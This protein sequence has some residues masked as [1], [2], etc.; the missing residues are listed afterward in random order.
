MFTLQD[1]ANDSVY[2]SLV[3]P[4]FNEEAR[5]AK[6][7]DRILNFL[8][9]QPYPA[10]VII[11]DDGSCDQ[12]VNVVRKIAL[13]T[14][15]LRILQSGANYGKGW[16][17][18]S[19][20]L[21]ARGSYLFF[22][23]ADLSVPIEVLPLF[24]AKLVDGFDVTIGTR[25][26]T[27]AFIEVHQPRYRELM[28][29]TYTRLSN[30]ILGLQVSDFTCGFKGFRRAAA[31]ELFFRQRLRRWSFDSEILYLARLK[32]YRVLEI[33]VTWRNDEATKVRLW[34]DAITSFL[35]L[36]QIRLHDFRGA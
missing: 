9:S 35:G 14:D 7:L 8:R 27:G 26:K 30:W 6:S 22:T 16:A 24:V 18:R 31:R 33:P 13:G 2:L 28:G 20:M 32:G 36:I 3:I 21:E 10:E 4:A 17:I 15:R 23:D 11:V 5:I 1:N 19:G 25:Q 12:T 34:K 29:K